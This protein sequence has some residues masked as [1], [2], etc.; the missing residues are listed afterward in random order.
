MQATQLYKETIPF[1]IMKWIMVVMS[2]IVCCFLVLIIYQLTQ[3]PMGTYPAPTWN[4]LLMLLLFLVVTISLINF[5]KLTVE[6]T[7]QSIT[8]RFG[9][10]KSNIPWDNV[11]SCTINKSSSFNYGG[12]GLRVKWIGDTWVRA[13][14]LN[15][16]SLIVLRLKS[17][18]SRQLVFSTKKPGELMQII[19]DFITSKEYR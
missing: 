19:N 3:G 18:K 16:S 5:L 1:S 13:Y 10:L 15:N 8:I 17:G 9:I 6:V 4:Y 12:W 11:K 2:I 14:I 7:T